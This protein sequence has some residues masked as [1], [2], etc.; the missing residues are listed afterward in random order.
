M[1]NEI[2][3]Y[4]FKWLELNPQYEQVFIFLKNK[5]PKTP[6]LII[7]DVIIS[8]VG[9]DE[10]FLFDVCAYCGKQFKREEM[11]T[12]LTTI[13]NPSPINFCTIKHI[14]EYNNKS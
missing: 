4:V 9:S 3:N 8:T 14:K 2:T 10:L 11:I 7:R 12:T 5:Y 13:G 6:D 1:E